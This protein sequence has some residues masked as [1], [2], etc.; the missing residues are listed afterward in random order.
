MRPTVSADS[1]FLQFKEQTLDADAL[2]VEVEVEVERLMQDA[3][4]E[5]KSGI[6]KYVLPHDERVLGAPSRL[7]LAGS[8]T[9]ICLS[10]PFNPRPGESCTAVIRGLA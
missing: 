9:L 10:L 3:E 8:F 7:E 1:Q 5:T 2:E 4:V 6:Y